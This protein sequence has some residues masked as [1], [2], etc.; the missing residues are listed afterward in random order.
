MMRTTL[1]TA[2]AL[3]ALAG[4]SEYDLK[5]SPEPVEPAAPVIQVTPSSI[6]FGML[7]PGTQESAFIQIENIGESPLTLGD[8][9]LNGSAAFTLTTTAAQQM[10]EPGETADAMVEYVATTGADTGN[11]AINSDDPQ[12]PKVKVPLNGGVAVTDKPIAVCSVDPPQVTAITGTATLIGDQSSDPNGLALEYQWSGVLRPNGSAA[13][14]PGG[15]AGSPNRPGFNPDLVGTYG[16]EL[17]VTNSDGVA[18]DPCFTELEAIP[19]DDLWVEMF[20]TYSGDD[21]DLHLTRNGAATTSTD[22]CYYANCTFG[23]LEWGPSGAAGNPTLDLDDIPGTG[24]ENINISQPEN[25]IYNVIVHDYPGSVYNG[26]N[27]VTVNIYLSGFLAWSDTRD[28]DGEG[29]Y[30]NIA[31]IDWAAQTVTPR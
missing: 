20:W 22:D 16:F 12:N 13:N 24:P 19:G 4:C 26:P 18:S 14:V 2:T 3:V 31:D 10:L 5:G 30:F 17:V 1:V 21:M 6:D 28:I 7:P 25:I 11:V 8:I 15:P 23:G 29:T 9:N 27:P